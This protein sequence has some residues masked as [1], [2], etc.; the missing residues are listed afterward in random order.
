MYD[1][2]DKNR[3]GFLEA[4]EFSLALTDCSLDIKPEIKN[5]IVREVFDTKLGKVKAA[6]SAK[7]SK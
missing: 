3:D 6:S 7:I 4:N 1:K 2:Y 5:M